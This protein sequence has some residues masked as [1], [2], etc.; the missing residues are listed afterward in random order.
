MA[1]KTKSSS[2]S[3]SYEGFGGIGERDAHDGG[4]YDI[5]NLRV[6][7]DGSLKKR[8]GYRAIYNAPDA[9]RAV[10]SGYIDGSFVCYFLAGRGIYTLDINTGEARLITSVTETEGHAQFFYFKDNL[11]LADGGDIYRLRDISAVSVKGYVPLLGKD[12]EPGEA[13]E[14]NEPLNILHRRARISYRVGETVG[15]YLPTMYPVASID[16]LYKNGALVDPESYSFDTRFNTINLSGLAT[17]DTLEANVTFEE[18]ELQAATRSQLIS[19]RCACIF[20]GINSSRLFL[21]GGNAKNK[22]FASIYVDER[23]LEASDA[24]YAGAGPLYFVEGSSFAVGDGRYNVK[25]VTRHFDRLLILTDGDAWIANAGT[26]GTEE[27]PIMNVNSSVGCTAER[28]VALVGND[29]VSIGRHAIYRWTSETDELNECNAYPISAQISDMLDQ[30]FFENARVIYSRRKDELWFADPTA[31]GGVFIYACKRG[32]WF[33]FEGIPISDF[34]DA[35]GEV[36]FIGGNTFYLFDDALNLDIDTVGAEDGREIEARLVCSVSDFGNAGYKRLGCA[37]IRA[38][39]LGAK[40][41]LTLK[42]DRGEQIERS[43][44]GK[45]AHEVFILNTP[46][47][48]FRTLSATL[49]LSGD[50]A[51]TLHGLELETR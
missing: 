15:A 31:D 28:G 48:R 10:W 34:F 17:G 30:S 8:S 42:S 7:A 50:A 11:Y 49:S 6:R 29:P 40:L 33:R 41:T 36:G 19:S 26:T 44:V 45:S 13:G 47:H 23:S 32:A 1:K 46:S 51:Q 4:I 38:D 2:L 16:A 43:A 24:R 14:I 35:D 39:S 5:V 37:I 9:I 12:W 3:L 22:I 27:F 18:D 20:G 21:W 25:A